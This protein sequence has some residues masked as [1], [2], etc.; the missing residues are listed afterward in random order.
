[1]KR[2]VILPV[3]LVIALPL[4]L[5]VLLWRTRAAQAAPAWGGNCLSCH[6]QVS[7]SPL[8]VVDPDTLADPDETA[9]GAPDRGT[10]KVFYG[11]RGRANRLTARVLGLSPNDTYAV[12]LKRLRF[13][14]VV[15]GGTLRYFPDCAWPEWGDVPAY[16]T[17]PAVA[18][19]A[20]TGPS[21][22]TYLIEVEP[23]AAKDFYDLVLAAGGKFAA[24]DQLFYGEEHFYLQV[25]DPG[26]FDD[27][28]T[29]NI[30]DWAIFRPCLAGPDVTTAPPFC[31]PLA[32]TLADLEDDEDVDLADFAQFQQLF[33]GL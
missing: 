19:R 6:A 11:Y 17:H 22:F 27:S 1:M 2:L 33:N 31:D 12:Q 14:G 5:G 30:T 7:P 24:D 13:P 10:L 23:N 18:H 26:D 15:S 3:V 16:Y 9:T 25:V 32:F 4:V 29:V 28:G 20:P 21:E 8:V